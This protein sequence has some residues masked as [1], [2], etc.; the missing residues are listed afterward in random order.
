MKINEVLTESSSNIRLKDLCQVKTNFPDADFWLIRTGTDKSV[1]TPTKTFSP[2]NIGIKV[3]ATDILDSRYLY[4]MMQHIHNTGYW[5]Q[6]A[7]G[8][9]RL[10]HLPLNNVANLPIG[11]NESLSEDKNN[12]DIKTEIS[13][14]DYYQGQ[15]DGYILASINGKS[16]FADEKNGYCPHAVGG[17]EFSIFDG[18][19]LIKM[20]N[21]KPEYQRL[22]VGLA[23][24][25]RLEQEVGKNNI[26]WGY[27]TDAGKRLHDK[28]QNIDEANIPNWAKKGALAAGGAAA[29]MTGA[30]SLRNKHQDFQPVTRFELPQDKQ[31]KHDPVKILAQTIWGEARDQ[32]TNGM[33][34]IGNVIKNRAADIKHARRFG[35]GII[36]VA[37]KPNQFSCWNKN[38]KNYEYAK[39]MKKI[40]NIMRTKHAP[41][42]Q[43]FNTWLK[44]FSN[45]KTHLDY[46]KWIESYKIA[47]QIL[48]GKLPDITHGALYYHTKDVHPY[49]AKGTKKLATIGDHIFYDTLKDVNE[50]VLDEYNVDN[51][52]GL[53]S[54][55]YNAN[56]NYMGL[57]VY[58][59]PSMFLKLAAKLSNP[60]SVDHIKQHMQSGGALGAPFLTIDIPREYEEGNFDKDARVVGHE[61]RNRMMAI[62]ELEGD[63]PV[64][65]HLFPRGMRAR[66]LTPE[67]IQHLQRSMFGQ[68][69]NYVYGKLF[70]VD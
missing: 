55:P 64:E 23:L 70:S 31:V 11:M 39:V 28:Y 17:L 59:K 8:S 12:I 16:P 24:V 62:Q 27:V 41:K 38:D 22:G 9:L 47:Q 58:M 32:G 2:E 53:G 48:S 68:D 57:K 66:H 63:E 43:D 56:V 21:V 30:L 69:G 14:T 3:L 18:K 5:K 36:G 6:F 15:H 20:V 35:Q 19:A 37:T 13:Y 49:W 33:I 67:I 60:T 42:G 7:V 34:A 1:G 50:T 51:V 46:K 40:D 54:V 4:Y 44:E 25:K 61:G 65:V 45:T 29:L 26:E 10:V 52:D